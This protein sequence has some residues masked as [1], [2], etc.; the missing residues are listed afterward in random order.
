MSAIQKYSDL[1]H[2]YFFTCI[3]LC[4]S[5][6]G[7]KEK[8][9]AAA[10]LKLE[11]LSQAAG[12][13]TD[14]VKMLPIIDE[15]LIN[16][17]VSFDEDSVVRVYP[18]V[19]GYIEELKVTLGTYVKKGQVM[20]TIKSGDITNY[21]KDY[22]TDKANLELAERQYR[23]TEQLYKSKFSSET[24]LQNAKKQ[25]QIAQTELKRSEEILRIYGGA[26][27]SKQSIF[28]V[29]AP[30]NGFVV[31]RNITAGQQLRPDNS[32]AMFVISDLNLVWV[33][34]N[35]YETDIALIAPSLEAEVTTLAYPDRVFKGKISNVSNVLDNQTK[36]LKI[37]IAIQ[38]YHNTLKPD[39][40]ATIRIHL[41][42]KEQYLAVP[43]K[44]IVFDREKY[45]LICDKGNKYEIRN[46]EVIKNTSSKVFIRGNVRAGEL[47]LTDGSLLMYN[48][49]S[50]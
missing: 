44:S 16:G 22:E 34:G 27:P 48:E 5:S 31:Q 30:I 13:K 19:S 14:T 1:K 20:A 35:V 11:S 49:L 41:P 17:Q 37:R 8:S 25:V 10:D 12:Y 23:N 9:M 39:M 43:P 47:V 26:H 45:F 29:K 33:L 2:F 40:F 42:Q 3:A 24:E 50:R 32:E 18:I 28:E 4:L 36:V 15:L 7:K 46:I 21:L 38:N 6:C